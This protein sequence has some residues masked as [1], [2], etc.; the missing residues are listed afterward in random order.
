MVGACVTPP[1]VYWLM[2]P[3]QNWGEFWKV[4]AGPIGTVLAAA[5]AV[6]AAY[7]ALHNG[8]RGR[9]QTQD[10]AAR[11][12][13]A[14]TERDLHSRFMSASVQM[15]GQRI[16]VR[17]A[18]AYMMAA[19]A[20]D[21]L[22]LSPNESL[23]QSREAQICIDMLCAYLRNTPQAHNEPNG[24]GEPTDQPVRDVIT[25]IIATHVHEDSKPSWRPLDFNLAGARLHDADL[26]HCRFEGRLS[27]RGAHFSGEQARFTGT[28]FGEVTFESAQFDPATTADFVRT[29]WNSNACFDSVQFGGDVQF[30]LAEFCKAASFRR[31]SLGTAV[32]A[33]SEASFINAKFFS[34]AVFADA[35]V[36]CST[37]DFEKATFTKEAQFERLC[38]AHDGHLSSLSFR[39]TTF[40]GP[41]NFINCQVDGLA[42]FTRAIFGGLSRK[43]LTLMT[44]DFDSEHVARFNHA[45]F[46][47]A[48]FTEARFTRPV[49]FYRVDFMAETAFI[50]TMF[51][52]PVRFEAAN[53]QGRG[54]FRYVE[55]SRG[56]T[57]HRATFGHDVVDFS[58]PR[59][60][61][62]V[63]FDWDSPDT[64]PVTGL[65]VQPSNVLP[66][67]WPPSMTLYRG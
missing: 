66:E 50:E 32:G 59:A 46:W 58:D 30:H 56:A 13:R 15:E 1:T 38:A 45:K 64:R 60:W 43:P 12:R 2:T 33:A 52:A 28:H 4:A 49:S 26:S 53:F 9:A 54:Q 35:Q 62:D 34:S 47:A 40:Q 8:E 10:D 48:R 44:A 24:A 31:A 7:L 11:D 41:V 57:F 36:Y 29:Q 17:Q 61:T 63:H 22:A 6:F 19:V 25:H 67:A 16:T 55:F 20:D 27:L 51:E 23:R 14:A 5:G 65:T 21:W 39:D 42:D 18:G 37:V 3:T